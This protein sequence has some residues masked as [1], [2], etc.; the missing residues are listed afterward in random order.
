MIIY[1]LLLICLLLAG[2]RTPHVQQSS[3]IT[4]LS[5]IADTVRITHSLAVHDT[6]WLPIPKVITGQKLCDSLCQQQLDALLADLRVA[7]QSGQSSY[8][9]YYDAYQRQLVLTQQLASQLSTQ[10]K[11]VHSQSLQNKETSV[12]RVPYTPRYIQVLAFIGT[13]TVVYTVF[14][15]KKILL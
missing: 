3:V 7:K 11:S 4:R 15:I 13:I 2:C 6:L 5:S 9:F 14:K 8:S 10:E 1:R 12:Q